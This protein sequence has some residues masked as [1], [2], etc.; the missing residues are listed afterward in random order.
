M[1]QAAPFS[2]D[3]LQTFEEFQPQVAR[4]FPSASSL[5]WFWRTHKTALV[6][7]GAV[8]RL[9]NRLL[10]DPEA[11]NR[12]AREIGQQQVAAL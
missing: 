10:V 3:R 6:Q 5:Y 11:F 8:V 1:E 2:I 12:V 7:A 4:V 9:N